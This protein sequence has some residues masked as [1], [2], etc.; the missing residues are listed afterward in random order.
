MLIALESGIIKVKD[1]KEI[2]KW[3]GM[4]DTVKYGYRPSIYHDIMVKEAFST[5]ALSHVFENVE[6]A[7]II[8]VYISLN[9]VD[10]IF[11]SNYRDV[12]TVY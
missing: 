5:I 9:V 3:L 1:E 4:T 7:L 6:H 10:I 2:V 12:N 8:P 11:N